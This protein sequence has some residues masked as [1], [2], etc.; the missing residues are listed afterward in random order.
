MPH[1]IIP[2]SKDTVVCRD[3]R[4]VFKRVHGVEAHFHLVQ[5]FIQKGVW[6]ITM[7]PRPGSNNVVL[8]GLNCTFRPI[9][10]LLI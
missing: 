3:P 5:H 6:T 7:K 4:I 1:E 8:S 10:F 9:R 2:F